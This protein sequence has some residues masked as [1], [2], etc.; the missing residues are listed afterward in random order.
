MV[1]FEAMHAV[2]GRRR[3]EDLAADRMA[4]AVHALRGPVGGLRSFLSLLV[5]GR[6]G[7]LTEKGR[8]FAREALKQAD[9]LNDLVTEMVEAYRSSRPGDEPGAA[10]M[11]KGE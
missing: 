4:A 9:K 3:L 8:Q 6:F 5:E 1:Y 2:G 10:S 11:S 7:T